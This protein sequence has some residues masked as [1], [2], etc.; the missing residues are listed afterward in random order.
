MK[1]TSTTTAAADDIREDID[2]TLTVVPLPTDVVKELFKEP[3]P[4]AGAEERSE[5]K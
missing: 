2:P 5:S 3:I 1:P 4:P